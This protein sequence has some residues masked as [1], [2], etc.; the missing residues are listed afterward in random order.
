M[1]DTAQQTCETS[2]A[3]HAAVPFRRLFFVFLFPSTANPSKEASW[4]PHDVCTHLVCDSDAHKHG[5]EYRHEACV[6]PEVLLKRSDLQPRD[7]TRQE[8]PKL[9]Q[10]PQGLCTRVCMCARECVQHPP[11][12]GTTCQHTVINTASTLMHMCTPISSWAQLQSNFTRTWTRL[13]VLGPHCVKANSRPVTATVV[14]AT[15]MSTHCGSCHATDTWL[16][17]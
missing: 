5:G 15:L 14:S 3:T 9:H 6:E 12:P 8:L 4:Q 2:S 1:W 11:T 7:H 10:R 17:S 16:L 13:R